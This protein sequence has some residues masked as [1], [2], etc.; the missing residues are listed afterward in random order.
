MLL[1]SCFEPACQVFAPL[2]QSSDTNGELFTFIMFSLA[3]IILSSVPVRVLMDLSPFRQTG[4][5]LEYDFPVHFTSNIIVILG[6]LSLT[7]SKISFWCYV[8]GI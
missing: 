4:T 5:G 8:M 1:Q 6:A 7:L 2:H 3:C